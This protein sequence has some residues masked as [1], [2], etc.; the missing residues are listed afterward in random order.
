MSHTQ[1]IKT[2]DNLAI[3]EVLQQHNVT[4]IGGGKDE[5]LMGENSHAVIHA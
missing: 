5:I 4:L 3:A 2:L 1:A